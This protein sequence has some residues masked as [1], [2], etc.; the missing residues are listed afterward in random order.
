MVVAADHVGDAHVVIV[1]HHRKHVG[2]RSIRAEQDEIVDLGIL[3][4]DPTLHLV[5]DNGL[6][7]AGSFKANDRVYSFTRRFR[8]FAPRAVYPK[9]P[10]LRK[11]AGLFRASIAPLPISVSAA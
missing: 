6:A 4:G 1:D 5:V 9:R 2:R 11:D 7:L 10:A 3:D 8:G